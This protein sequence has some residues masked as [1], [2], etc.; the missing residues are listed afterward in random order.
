[1]KRTLVLLYGAVVYAL[2]MATLVYAIGFVADLGVPKSINSGQE[3]PIGE[4]LLVNLLLLSL[5][6]VQ[7]SGMARLGFKR[8]WTR[9]V[10]PSI[11]RSTYG[12]ATC[13]AFI[14]LFWLWR[15]M[16]GVVWS[17]ES[18]IAATALD[19]AH[20]AGWGIVVLSTFMVGHFD[21][22]GLRQVWLR[23]R[24][25]P[26]GELQFRAVGFYK[27][28]RHPIQAGF[29]IVFWATPHMTVGR[30][31]FA[32]VS[33]AY[34]IVALKLFEERDLIKSFGDTYRHYQRQVG[35]FVPRRRYRPNA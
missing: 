23:W 9:R 6:A 28:I 2:S 17:V 22:F 4:A 12:L 1:M 11:E 16:P 18:P 5:F 19:V 32:A 3:G 34:I 31:L 29:V 35:M 30:L 20:W 14:L 26:Y 27:F 13:V 33:T 15:P 25:T 8:W 7:H 21:L 24:R 10:P